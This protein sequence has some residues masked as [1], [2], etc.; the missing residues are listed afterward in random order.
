MGF[1]SDQHVEAFLETVPRF[2]KMLTDDGIILV[3]YWLSC[4]QDELEERFAE[5]LAD[6]LKRWKLSPI[7]VAA[8]AHYADYTAAREAMFAA[9]HTANAPWTV[10][11]ANDKR[12]ARVK[13]VETVVESLELGLRRAGVEVGET[14]RSP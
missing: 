3:K 4:D 7:D 1:A 14:P 10:V 2:E 9:S 5:R 12:H 6:P 13:V 8:R 11:E